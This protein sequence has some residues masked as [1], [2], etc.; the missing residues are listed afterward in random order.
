MEHESLFCGVELCALASP[1]LARSYQPGFQQ[2]EALWVGT[3][4]NM[5]GFL[6]ENVGWEED[7]NPAALELPKAN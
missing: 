2:K 5:L 1:A 3:M 4:I 6:V 7:G